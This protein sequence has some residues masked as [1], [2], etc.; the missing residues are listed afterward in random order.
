MNIAVVTGASSG[1]GEEFVKQLDS[2]KFDEI[3]VI[4]RHKDKLEKLKLLTNTKLK[5]IPLDLSLD[6]SFEIYE[7]ELAE[8]DPNVQLLINCAGFGKFGDYSE[9]SLEDSLKMIDLNCK[10]L[11]SMTVKTLPYM[12]EFSKILQICSSSSFQ[13]LPLANVYASTKSFV[14]S[15]SR[16]LNY[17]LKQRRILVTAVCPGWVRTNFFKTANET[18]NPKA[19]NNYAFMSDAKNVVKKALHDMKKNK[20]ISIYG[21]FSLAQFIATKFFPRDFIMNIWVMS[22]K[23]SNKQ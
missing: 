23:S 17:E 5:V 6:S 19:V 18:K 22:Q 3:W 1:L 15:Y 8:N 13:P 11:V 21:A 16:A 7:N 10:A 14:L 20:S 9:I 2:F 4:A 12:R